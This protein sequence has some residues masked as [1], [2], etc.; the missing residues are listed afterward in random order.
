MA[1][2]PTSPCPSALR[3]D[4]RTWLLSPGHDLASV[5]EGHVPHGSG[6]RLGVH[7]DLVPAVERDRGVV[8]V[9]DPALDVDAGVPAHDTPAP[10]LRLRAAGQDAPVL[11][12]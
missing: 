10:A 2:T 1:P 11:R 5:E 4:N 12:L 7:D 8:G 6:L 3:H 9:P